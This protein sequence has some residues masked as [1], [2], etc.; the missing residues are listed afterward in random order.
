MISVTRAS[1]FST[2]QDGG[3][4]GFMSSGVPRAGA[5]DLLTLHTLN[6]MV[7]NDANAAA[8]EWALTGG[9]IAFSDRTS[10]ALGGAGASAKLNDTSVDPYRAYLASPG[11][12]LVVEGVT[13]GRF[14][15]ITFS[16]GIDT[17]PVMKSRS[18]YLPGGFGGLEGRRLKTGDEI[19]VA[20]Q[21]RAR[22][23]VLDALPLSLRP[24]YATSM[25]RIV[26]NGDASEITRG[27]FSISPSSDRMGYRLAG[28]MIFGGAGVTSTG[29]CP[30]TI[31]L[32][33]G[34][35][36]I[37]LMADAPTIGGYRIVGCVATVDLGRF[38]QLTPGAVVKF[39]EITV[40]AAQRLL[41]AEDHRLEAIRDWALG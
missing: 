30:G 25:I 34:G 22:H 40:E 14:L 11:D 36:P 31:E 32:P 12:K 28:Q 19:P 37:V 9:E 17:P 7:G 20:V 13:K 1:S 39:E 15:Y 8:I 33:P 6:A 38:A 3:R 5:M 18:T 26:A 27:E 35:E 4:V 41:I 29:M 10:F 2:I 24:D 21:K 23:M 16:G